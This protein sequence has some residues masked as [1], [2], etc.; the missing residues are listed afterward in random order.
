MMLYVAFFLHSVSFLSAKTHKIVLPA[1]S[2]DT[3]YFVVSDDNYWHQQK[4]SRTQC[5]APHMCSGRRVFI[6]IFVFCCNTI[7]KRWTIKSR[8]IYRFFLAPVFFRD[9]SVCTTKRKRKKSQRMSF[10]MIQSIFIRFTC[11]SDNNKIRTS[12]MRIQLT[13]IEI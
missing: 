7:K 9:V 3:S 8:K 13:S 1:W 6:F 4:S 2:N 12:C 5:T 10:H 11:V